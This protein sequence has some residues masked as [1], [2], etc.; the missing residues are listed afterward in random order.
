MRLLP[1]DAVD[2]ISNDRGNSSGTRPLVNMVM[3]VNMVVH[4]LISFVNWRRLW[5]RL[6]S[7]PH[8]T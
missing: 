8:Y 6:N 7:L 3:R 4:N 1:R 2:A 5:T